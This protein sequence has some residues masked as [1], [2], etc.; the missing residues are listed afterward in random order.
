MD[1]KKV[2][3]GGVSGRIA[4]LREPGELGGIVAAGW[5]IGWYGLFRRNRG[6]RGYIDK[7]E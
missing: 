2:L 1:N 7:W 6:F 5:R 4:L 3:H